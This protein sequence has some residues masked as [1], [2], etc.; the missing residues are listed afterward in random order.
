MNVGMTEDQLLTAVLDLA[1][2]LG[3]RS[4]HIRPPAS[5]RSTVQ[6]DG[7]GFPDLLLIRGS[8]ILV[9]EL[10]DATGRVDPRQR[11]W[12]N[13]FEAAGIHAYVWRPADWPWAIP[14][15]LLGH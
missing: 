8:E 11:A 6:G 1:K 13:S 7:K 14:S 9:A 3:W 4:L 2:N 15:V 10:K 5:A 12:L